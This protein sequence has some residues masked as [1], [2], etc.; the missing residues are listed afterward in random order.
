MNTKLFIRPNTDIRILDTEYTELALVGLRVDNINNYEV[1]VGDILSIRFDNPTLTPEYVGDWEVVAI[2]P[3][4][5][6]CLTDPLNTIVIALPWGE[7]TGLNPGWARNIVRAADGGLLSSAGYGFQG[8]GFNGTSPYMQSIGELSDGTLI[9]GGVFTTYNGVSA[10]RIVGINP[11]GTINATFSYGT[12]FIGGGQAVVNIEVDSQDRVYVGG[13]FTSYNGTTASCIIR[14]TATGSVDPTFNIGTGLLGGT[15]FAYS[16]ELDEANGRI[17]IGGQFTT[18]NG[19]S[20]NRIVCLL[21]DG[22]IDTSFNYGTGFAAAFGTR[23]LRLGP[24]DK[25]YCIGGF[26]SYNGT[27]INRICRL[28]TDGTLDTSFVVGTGFN[29]EAFDIMFYGGKIYVSGSFTQYDGVSAN[30]IIRLNNDG[31]RDNLFD[32]GTGLDN[33]GYGIINHQGFLYVFGLFTSYNGQAANKIAVLDYFG[34]LNTNYQGQFNSGSYVFVIYPLDNS[35]LIGGSFTSYN[36]QTV[37]RISIFKSLL[38]SIR[39]EVKELNL[40]EDLQFPLTY[41]IIDIKEPQNRKSDYSKSITLPGTKNNNQILAQLFE[42]GADS[43]YNTN[44]KKDIFV[45]QDGL[46]IF[47]GYIKIENINREN[48]NDISYDVKISGKLID[49]FSKLF[50]S[51]KKDLKLS[52][53]DYSEWDHNKTR[54]TILGSWNGVVQKNGI[55]YSNY[56]V[57]PSYSV[58]DTSFATGHFTAFDIGTHSLQIGDVVYFEMDLPNDPSVNFNKSQGHHTIISVTASYVVVNLEFQ[59]GAT[60]TGVLTKWSSNGEGYVYPTIDFGNQLATDWASSQYIPNIYAKTLVD[61]IFSTIGFQYDS[62]FFGSEFF[63]RLVVLG[64]AKPQVN[65]I[66]SDYTDDPTSVYIFRT[67]EIRSKSFATLTTTQFTLESFLYDDTVPFNSGSQPCLLQ[68]TWGQY[69]SNNQ[70]VGTPSVTTI[71]DLPSSIN[72]GVS[73]LSGITWY[74]VKVTSVSPTFTLNPGDYIKVKYDRFTDGGAEVPN[75]ITRGYNLTPDDFNLVEYVS[76]MTCKDFLTSLISMFNLYVEPDKNNDRTLIIEPFNDYYRLDSDAKD[77]TLKVDLSRDYEITPISPNVP[78]NNQ[79]T[80]TDDGDYFNKDFKDQQQISYGYYETSQETDFNN[81]TQVTKVGFSQTLLVDRNNDSARIIIPTIVKDTSFNKIEQFKPRIFYWTGLR[82]VTNF[83]INGVSTSDVY[84]LPMYGYAGHF[85]NP[86]NATLD[87]NFNIMPKYYYGQNYLFKVSSN[88]LFKRYYENYYNE[89]TD[90]STKLLKCYM[91]LNSYDISNLSFRRLYY[92]YNNLYRLQSINDYDPLLNDSVQCQFIK[93]KEAPSNGILPPLEQVEVTTGGLLPSVG[94]FNSIA[95]GRNIT[96]GDISDTGIIIGEDSRVEF[97]S[98]NYLINGS[99]ITIGTA[100]RNVSAFGSG[101]RIGATTSNIFIFGTNSTVSD[102]VENAYIFGNG[103]N[104]TQSN[105]VYF[106]ST[107]TFSGIPGLGSFPDLEQVL[108]TG[109]QVGNLLF[110]LGNDTIILGQAGIG[111]NTVTNSSYSYVLGGSNILNNSPINFVF[112]SAH[113]LQ[114]GSSWNAVFGQAAGPFELN[115]SN[116]NFFTSGVRGALDSDGNFAW[117]LGPVDLINSNNNFL[118]NTDSGN[119]LSIGTSSGSF[120][121]GSDV[122]IENAN[123]NM[124]L[125]LNSYT[126]S[127]PTSGIIY[128]S[129]VE[130]YYPTIGTISSVA[131]N[132]TVTMLGNPMGGQIKLLATGGVVAGGQLLF[133]LDWATPFTTYACTVTQLA[134]PG[135]SNSWPLNYSIVRGNG[136]QTFF[137]SSG[138]GNIASGDVVILTYVNAPY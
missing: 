59:S 21:E 27:N 10:N 133:Q 69:D 37:N 31:S 22:T 48:W 74:S 92:I 103:I 30:R 17:Y 123:N 93:V 98:T 44:L 64:K 135:I 25:L 58:S 76:D 41:N 134:D 4:Y 95:V 126:N 43:T 84:N 63:K 132:L 29:A 112:G 82:Y 108:N 97:G 89:I 53:L 61:K 56:T 115:N 3:T 45:T 138:A 18:Y 54:D 94:R 137:Y 47:N 107:F 77:W 14:L 96:V 79:Y 85:D 120:V 127:T 75:T 113:I 73:P 19:T 114:N 71:L 12:G 111:A 9:I 55:T 33:A 129:P 68:I 128:S 106:D 110:D 124:F 32:I 67:N 65:M 60:N 2:S 15:P 105:A 51:D 81:T 8:S 46:E 66:W 119:S 42:I 86:E 35:L 6:C 16:I 11:D 23:R 117:G 116:H 87:L 125:N 118:L 20:A 39:Y 78:R 50:T 57:G 122:N 121:F 101:L 72:I 40:K 99:D 49:I 88:T 91:K 80:Y 26:T 102:G 1:E 131:T 62:E 13:G 90:P 109:N 83:T 52:D 7:S 104:A 70:I 36:G 100:S 34:N 28:N 38:R 24:D 130:Y 136:L 5:S